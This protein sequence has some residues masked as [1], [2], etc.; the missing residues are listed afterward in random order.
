VLLQV[1]VSVLLPKTATC[2]NPVFK[3][4]SIDYTDNPAWFNVSNQNPV[5]Q[6]E[7][8]MKVALRKGGTADLNVY[9]NKPSVNGLLGERMWV[10]SGP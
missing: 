10:V 1:P 5:N 9:S 7:F 8:D 6:V 4:N 3:L 2:W